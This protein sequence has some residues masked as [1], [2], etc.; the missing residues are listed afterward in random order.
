MTIISQKQSDDPIEVIL[1]GGPPDLP[2]DGRILR[3][4]ADRRKVKVAHRGGYEHFERVGD[5]PTPAPVEFH[6]TGRTRVAE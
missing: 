2:V 6:W 1:V 5:P 4:D 3:I